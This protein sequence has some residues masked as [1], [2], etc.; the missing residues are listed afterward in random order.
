MYD[1][2]SSIANRAA[3]IGSIAKTVALSSME[4]AQTA[5][6]KAVSMVTETSDA[7]KSTADQVGLT[8]NLNEGVCDTTYHRVG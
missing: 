8:K 1:G 4:M 3:D 5:G 7:I 2:F 6:Q